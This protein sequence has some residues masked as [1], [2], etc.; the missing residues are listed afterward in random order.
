L[1]KN[2]RIKAIVKQLNIIAYK[3][4]LYLL[5]FDYLLISLR[6][7]VKKLLFNYGQTKKIKRTF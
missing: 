1:T 6:F 5:I 2:I 4:I 3:N 7:F